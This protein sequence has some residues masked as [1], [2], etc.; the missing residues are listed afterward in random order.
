MK[1]FLEEFDIYNSSDDPNS[2]VGD[3]TGANTRLDED[4]N[5]VKFGEFQPV[6]TIGKRPALITNPQ[7]RYVN[8]NVPGRGNLRIGPFV[9]A[10]IDDGR[11]GFHDGIDEYYYV[12]QETARDPWIY[13]GNKDT[14]IIPEI[15]KVTVGLGETIPWSS[16]TP[17]T[18]TVLNPDGN[19][20]DRDWET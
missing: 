19:R 12:T 7:S 14:I 15:P 1:E 9:F 6:G 16:L 3:P 20:A 5:W 10:P 2:S 18:K 17:G 4:P 13:K 8:I 11:L